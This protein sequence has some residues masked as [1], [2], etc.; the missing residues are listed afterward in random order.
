[1]VQGVQPKIHAA[2]S[3]STNGNV[4]WLVRIVWRHMDEAFFVTD[5]EF[6]LISVKV[7]GDCYWNFGLRFREI[8]KPIKVIDRIDRDRRLRFRPRSA[9]H[10]AK[11]KASKAIMRR[12]GTLPPPPAPACARPLRQRGGDI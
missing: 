8:D 5:Q 3:W 10:L 12:K 11:P 4:I 2:V 7:D 1:M 6:D 9:R